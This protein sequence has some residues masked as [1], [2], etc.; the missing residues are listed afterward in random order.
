MKHKKN[1]EVALADPNIKKVM[2]AA[3]KTFK[4]ELDCDEIYTCKINALWKCLKNFKPNKN[5]KFTTYLWQGVYIECLKE[6]KFK[7][8]S[9]RCNGKLHDNIPK[10]NSDILMVD[11]LDEVDNQEDKDLLLDKISNLTIKEMSEKRPYS[12][13]TARKKIKKITNKIKSKFK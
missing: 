6:L 4:N 5:T 11:I 8:K 2:S 9:R 12:R 7:Q 3:C 1:I 10:H 13:E